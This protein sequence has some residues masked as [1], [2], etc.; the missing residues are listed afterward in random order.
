MSR[1]RFG[2]S[3]K[4]NL[5]KKSRKIVFRLKKSIHQNL[6]IFGSWSDLKNFMRQA[7]EVTYTDAHIRSGENRGE[8]C[9]KNR[10]GLYTAKVCL[11]DQSAAVNSSGP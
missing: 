10:K 9:F 5:E 8:V 3:N 1:N 11:R 2:I 6:T 7:G 4:K